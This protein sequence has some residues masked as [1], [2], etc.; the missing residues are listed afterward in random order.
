MTMWCTC[1]V[2]SPVPDSYL[3]NEHRGQ[4]GKQNYNERI[5]KIYVL[6]IVYTSP[7]LRLLWQLSQL[8]LG[9]PE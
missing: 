9:L 3:K 2:I 5:W 6:Q 7:F 4:Y 1:S 8:N